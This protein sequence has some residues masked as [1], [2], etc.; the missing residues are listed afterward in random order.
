MSPPGPYKNA[1]ATG[2]DDDDDDDELA[3]GGEASA[4][5][6]GAWRWGEQRDAAALK[7][8]GAMMRMRA[9]GLDWRGWHGKNEVMPSSSRR[10]TYV[11]MQRAWMRAQ[12]GI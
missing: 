6:G 8:M 9:A 10:A 2:G 4:V 11:P 3:G 7:R 1:C 12:D 5:G